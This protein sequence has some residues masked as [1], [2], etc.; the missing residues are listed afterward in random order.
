MPEACMTNECVLFSPVFQVSA[1]EIMLWCIKDAQD[2]IR[3]TPPPP[4]PGF[5]VKKLL[6]DYDTLSKCAETESIEIFAATDN[7]LKL[8]VVTWQNYGE[9]VKGFKMEAVAD[10]SRTVSAACVDHVIRRRLLSRFGLQMDNMPEDPIQHV[11]I[12]YTSVLVNL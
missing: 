10:V 1:H 6:A 7:F 4:L 2:L 3:K 11:S 8:Q 5:D 12:S 9:V